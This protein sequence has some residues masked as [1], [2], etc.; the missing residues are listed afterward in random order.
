MKRIILSILVFLPFFG[1]A[2]IKKIGTPNIRNYPKTQY[3]GGTQNWDI[4]QDDKGF[5]YFANNNGIMR[6][7]GFHWDFL[8]LSIP[9]PVRSVFVDSKNRI[10]VGAIDN[11]GILELDDAGQYKFKSLRYL[12]KED[13]GFS[14]VW[15]IHE[16]KQGIVFQAF[17]KLFIYHNNQISVYSPKEKYRFS[18]SINGRFFVQEY[19]YGLYEYL[20]GYFEKVPWSTPL[21][22][23][24]ILSMQELGENI[25]LIGTVG[26]FY[27][28]DHGV[29]T[30]W[31]TEVNN[32]IQTNKLFSFASVIGNYLAFGTILNGV[33]IS[34]IN[35]NVIQHLTRESGLQNNT[36]LSLFSDKDGNLW[37]GLDNGIDYVEINSP[38]SYFSEG[39]NIGTGYCSII[40]KNRLYLGTNQ[41]LYVKPFQ[42]FSEE[43]GEFKFVKN[44]EGQVWSL[45]ECNGKLICGH[46]FGT[47]LIEEDHATKI[48][49]EA[50]GWTYMQLNENKNRLIG[51]FYSGLALFNYQNGNW[52]FD[53]K[54][55]GFAESSRF[56]FED[57]D[58]DFWISHGSKGVFKVVINEAKDSAVSVKLY[59]S[60][61]GLP[62]N[63]K[64]IVL[65]FNNKLYISTIDGFYEYQNENDVF[66][67]SK[68]MAELTGEKGRIK[69]IVNDRNDNIWFI[70]ENGAGVLRKNEDLTYTKITSPFKSLDSHYVLEFEF[71]YP[72][73]SENVLIGIDNGFAHYS[74]KFP[75][76]YGQSYPAYITK[77]ELS[78]LDSIIYPEANKNHT[79]EFPFKQNSFRF[80]FT[81]PLFENPDEVKFSYFLENFSMEWSNWSEDIYKDFTNLPPGTFTF[82]V[83]ALS[84]YGTESSIDS[85]TFEVLPPWYLSR[86]AYV[87]YIALFL[88]FIVLLILFL[89]YRMRLSEKRERLKHE[90][91]MRE[92]EKQFQHQSV[93]AEKEIIKLRNEKLRATM[94]HRDKELANQTNSIIQKN[95]FLL[96]L[97][98]ELTKLSKE[99]S[100]GAAKTKLAILK[101]KIDKE[102]DNK[103]QNKIFET[104]FDEVHKEFFERLKEKYPQLSPKDLRLC[105]YIKM[106]ISTKEIATLLNISD[107]GAEISRYRLRKK[108][109]LPRETNL[110]TFLSGI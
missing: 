106:N 73:N 56:L 32:L 84:S 49:T 8:D 16:T 78:N 20:N 87:I 98:Q 103:R 34:D 1:F 33:I 102:I 65:P 9:L 24:E 109:E 47:F 31:N 101:K 11:F 99:T 52:K 51:G 100:D 90:K 13:V 58:G 41:G 40:H 43:K 46:N 104:Y 3:N 70:S 60:N 108:L 21:A 57:S 59:N 4:S 10:F 97:N 83:K 14:D 6:F 79:L 61:S 22:N 105:A 54:I 53:R 18:F 64:N 69:T 50:G 15:R 74:S 68:K 42:N 71:I 55:K 88:V 19:K 37:L 81:S 27:K 85:F 95:R 38:I 5:M 45:T 29:L 36:V 92:K 26:G 35:G 39:G 96:K 93:V 76:F 89:R 30:K 75:K 48:N 17:E 7:D 107:R 12:I 25:I 91:E 2:Q 67:P 77:I 66:I 23:E 82:K 80:H 63:E 86:V 94:I 72:F 62:S 110:S 44:T 28:Y